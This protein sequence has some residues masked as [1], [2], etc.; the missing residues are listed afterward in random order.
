ML[1]VFTKK[2]HISLI[3]NGVDINKFKQI[4]KEEALKHILFDPKK[5]HIVF[6][7]HPERK[8][9]NYS[10]AES[11]VRL[12]KDS[13]I[14]LHSIHGISSDELVYY[15][16]GAD[17]MVLTS[18]HEGSPNVIKEAMACNCP[19]V[20]TDVGDIKWVIGK[21]N[22]CFIAGFDS[23]DFSK[24]IIDALNCTS[25]YRQPNGLKRIIE[26]GLDSESIA[27]R[28]IELYKNILNE[29]F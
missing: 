18:F 16:N 24:K 15:Y 10:L 8:V 20:A 29:N 6:I 12:L 7:S 23:N 14:E 27:K 9:K 2:L 26:L 22:G 11:S 1:K 13:S 4:D 5:K 21:T 25:S 3:P 19:I 17:L 28:I